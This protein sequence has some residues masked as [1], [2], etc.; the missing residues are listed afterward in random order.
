IV[1]AVDTFI[2][3]LPD[4]PRWVEVR[5]MLL[6]GRGQVYG[7]E[8]DPTPTGIIFQPDTKL[9]AIVG[10]P[11]VDLIQ[12]IAA[13]ADEILVAP[14]DVGWVTPALPNWI[15]ESATLHLLKAPHLLTEPVSASV[16]LLNPNET[17]AMSALPPMLREELEIE[18]RAGTPI[19]AMWDAECPVAFCYAGAVTETLWDVAIDTLSFH[20]RKGYASQCFYYLARHMAQKGKHPVWGAVKSNLA[21]AQLATKL[22]FVAVDSLFVYSR[23]AA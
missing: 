17:Q 19:A 2:A 16:R 15:A 5:G 10:R 23:D 3:T 9:A 13:Q 20:R 18:S 7:L 14:E 21:S 1:E 12:E 11:R 4:I 22:G 8:L 6:S